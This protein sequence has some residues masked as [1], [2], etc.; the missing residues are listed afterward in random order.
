MDLCMAY[1]KKVSCYLNF[2]RLGVDVFTLRTI[3]VKSYFSA[4][5]VTPFH[6]K[7]V[8]KTDTSFRKIITI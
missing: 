3:L 7:N 4:K 5:S 1:K 6:S 8:T 2:K